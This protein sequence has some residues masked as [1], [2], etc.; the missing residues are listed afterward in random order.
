[1]VLLTA[2]A[3]RGEAAA[4]SARGLVPD[5]GSVVNVRR[6]LIFGSST[7]PFSSS[8][9]EPSI[10]RNSMAIAKVGKIRMLHLSSCYRAFMDQ[11]VESHEHEKN[12]NS[13]T[14]DLMTS[15][16]VLAKPD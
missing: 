7:V 4:R 14:A 3:C 16:Q 13:L 1:M 10:P 6:F 2:G 15:F 9:D 8:E 5:S 11:S 12:E